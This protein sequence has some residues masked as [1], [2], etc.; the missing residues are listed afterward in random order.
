M[1]MA[2]SEYDW[3]YQYDQDKELIDEDY[4]TLLFLG[5]P[6]RWHR[7]GLEEFWEFM[8]WPA[9]PKKGRS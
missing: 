1:L 9:V 3:F 6:P 7:C 2:I 5:G 4:D 8:R